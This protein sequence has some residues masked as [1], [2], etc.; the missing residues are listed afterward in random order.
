MNA[1]LAVILKDPPVSVLTK[2]AVHHGIIDVA[3]EG[4]MARSTVALR[5]LSDHTALSVCCALLCR[6][7]APPIRTIITTAT[8][9]AR[10]KSF[11]FMAST[12][13]AK[14]LFNLFSLSFG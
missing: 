10:V 14:V 2:T 5:S 1:F 13:T 8:R 4:L 11:T 9:P 7:A 3:P 6:D 12:F